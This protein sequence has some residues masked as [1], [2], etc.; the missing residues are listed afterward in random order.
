MA[1]LNGGAYARRLICLLCAMLLVTVALPLPRA[2]AEVHISKFQLIMNGAPYLIGGV[3]IS[4]SVADDSALN[5]DVD[6]TNIQYSS[7]NGLNWYPVQEL[8]VYA[9][10]F[11]GSFSLPLDV[12]ITSVILK[13]DAEYSPLFGSD[14]H[15]SITIG[16]FPVKQPVQLDGLTLTENKGGSVTLAWNDNSNMESYYQIKRTGGKDGEKVLYVNDTMDH[17]GPLSFTDPVTSPETLYVYAVEM[18]IDKFTLPVYLIPGDVPR[19]FQT[20]KRTILDSNIDVISVV[21]GIKLPD[22]GQIVGVI[23]GG[24]GGDT[25]SS[26]GSGS[27]SGTVSGPPPLSDDQLATLVAGASEWAKPDL[28]EAIKQKLTTD[29]V[30]GK[31]Q[32][33][34]TREEFAG[35]VVQL[36]RVNTGKPPQPITSNPFSDTTDNQVLEASN[37]GIVKGTSATTFS[38]KATI[39]RQEICVMLYR[40]AQAA[41]PALVKADNHPSFTD[42]SQ[43]AAW[44]L[45]AVG[46]LSS[47]G[48]MKGVGGGK[49]DPLGKVTR[50][51]AIALIIRAY[52][53]L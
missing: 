16:P 52:K 14:S 34:I 8:N 39:T 30:L 23:P 20:K 6:S 12:S 22:L 17:M 5:T 31:Y 7:D 9:P 13:L 48:I 35:I 25:G 50:E 10:G 21:P 11:G 27:G 33:S 28:I 26:S 49:V 15:P 46:F 41:D 53:T 1:S 19:L 51:Q 24:S 32:E 45:D 47:K 38:P 44:A 42:K 40:A 3:K 36:Y 43:I 29:A 2:H 4:Y 37:L 18:I